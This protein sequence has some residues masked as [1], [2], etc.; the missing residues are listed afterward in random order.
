MSAWLPG[1]KPAGFPSARCLPQEDGSLQSDQELRLTC[2]SVG[3]HCTAVFKQQEGFGEERQWDKRAVVIFRKSSLSIHSL[4]AIEP[5]KLK[6]DISLARREP[7][8][9]MAKLLV[10]LDFE[11][12]LK[13]Q[14]VFSWGRRR[15]FQIGRTQVS[16]RGDKLYQ[17]VLVTESSRVTEASAP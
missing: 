9:K 4:E 5:Y 15:S 11:L 12:G 10:R 2:R 14:V 7:A 3:E 13:W 16:G 17:L 1:S 8:R 6:A